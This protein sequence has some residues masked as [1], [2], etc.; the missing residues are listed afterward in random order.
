M[1]VIECPARRAL[2]VALHL[3]LAGYVQ[4]SEG[5]PPADPVRSSRAL[6]DLMHLVGRF[7]LPEPSEKHDQVGDVPWPRTFFGGVETVK[8]R[9]ASFTTRSPTLNGL[10]STEVSHHLSTIIIVRTDDRPSSTMHIDRATTQSNHRLCRSRRSVVRV[11][12][13][14]RE[15]VAEPDL[16]TQPCL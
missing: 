14:A 2:S 15:M 4:H 11:L 12:M 7:I 16:R 13:A 3:H 10:S 8:R 9:S 5:S 6:V 1:A